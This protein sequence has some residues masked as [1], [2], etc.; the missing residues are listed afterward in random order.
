MVGPEDEVG[1]Q[2]PDAEP[3]H[4]GKRGYGGWR[5]RRVVGG[6]QREVKVRFTDADYER[7]AAR[8]RWRGRP[9]RR[10]WRWRGCGCRSLRAWPGTGC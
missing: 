2:S 1:E 6:R 3:Q 7:V 4:S 9:S 5:Q 8:A 10:I